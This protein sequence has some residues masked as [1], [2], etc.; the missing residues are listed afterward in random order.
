[1]ITCVYYTAGAIVGSCEAVYDVIVREPVAPGAALDPAPVPVPTQ[2]PDPAL[3][4]APAMPSTACVLYAAG[5]LIGSCEALYDFLLR[6]SA[7]PAPAPAPAPAAAP[8]PAPLP[9]AAPVAALDAAPVPASLPAAAPVKD[10][11]AAPD[12]TS[13]P[14][15]TAAPAPTAA[16][17]PAPLPA[18]APVPAPA[19]A[20]SSVPSHLVGVNVLSHS[21][22]GGYQKKK[23]KKKKKKKTSGTDAE[24][25]T[26]LPTNNEAKQDSSKATSSRSVLERQQ[27]E[28]TRILELL[29]H[30]S[31][32][33]WE[34]LNVDKGTTKDKLKMQYLRLMLLV[35]PSRNSCE[36]AREAFEAVWLAKMAM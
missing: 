8:V 11:T 21:F 33:P 6:E 23:N 19:A 31:Y 3:A 22:T 13:A 32:E 25:S 27:K 4:A 28:L 30:G 15:P 12:P 5:A 34:L 1:M 18:V 14:G 35:H 16:P 24:L 20:P 36:R 2:V 17:V 9:A 7:A 10:P 29:D 26:P